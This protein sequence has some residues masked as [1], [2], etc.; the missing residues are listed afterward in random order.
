MKR[1]FPKFVAAA[2]LILATASIASAGK[3]QFMFGVKPGMLIQTSYFGLSYNRLEPFVGLDWVA[4]SVNSDGGDVAG[5]VFIPHF[6]S[7][8]YL[9]SKGAQHAIAPYLLGDVFFSLASVKVEGAAS[10]EEAAIKDLL[11]FWG[12]TLGFG[13]EY[14]FSDKFS[15]GG[16][17][18]LRLLFDKVSEHSKE[19]EWQDYYGDTHT[20]R[21]KVND[22]FT[23]AFRVTY[24]AVSLNYHF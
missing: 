22:E 21:E 17:W 2:C 12:M 7:R 5:S 16:E 15:V 4:V 23:V 13:T 24:A 18:G 19:E 14:Y 6:G 10:E 20:Y 8:W 1:V 3:P 9:K 11:E